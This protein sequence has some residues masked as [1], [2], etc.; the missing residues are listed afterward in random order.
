MK[1]TNYIRVIIIMQA[2]SFSNMLHS[3][4]F[5]EEDD[6][7]FGVKATN[8]KL[9]IDDDLKMPD[10]I[11]DG[12]IPTLN[13]TGYMTSDQCNLSLK[14]IEDAGKA[15]LPVLDIGAAYGI[16]TLPALKLGAQVIANDIDTRHLLLLR[17]QAL[18]KFWE[19]LTLNRYQFPQFTN[20]PNESLD[21]ILINRVSHFL[22]PDEMEETLQ[23]AFKWLTPGGRLYIITMSP[24]H[25]LLER[26]LPVYNQRV[27][28]KVIWAGDIP[29]MHDYAPDLKHQIPQYL[30]VMDS[31][32]LGAAIKLKGFKIIEESLF[33]YGHTDI[34]K[35]NGK[36]YY[37][38]IAEKSL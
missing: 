28:N 38:V 2:I 35:A 16:T 4:H 30:H 20:F 9:K 7:E 27:H 21:I 11:E 1:L 10:P 5:P 36:G 14:F 17:E 23:K 12:K 29:N 6:T 26:F 18:P 15:T 24:H 31:H 33:D 37:G 19:R 13:K 32:S 25:Y 34:K 22:T 8:P 3:I